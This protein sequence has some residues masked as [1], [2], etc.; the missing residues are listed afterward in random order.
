[1]K[2][3]WILSNAFSASNEMINVGIIGT[4]EIQVNIREDVPEEPSEEPSDTPEE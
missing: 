4:Y 1:M 3:C 2:R